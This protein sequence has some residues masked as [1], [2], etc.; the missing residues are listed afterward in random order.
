MLV[1]KGGVMWRVMEGL[2]GE[3]EDIMKVRAV[4]D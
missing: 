2:R 3:E 4:V 1:L